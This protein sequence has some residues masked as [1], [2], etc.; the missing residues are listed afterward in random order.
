VRTTLNLNNDLLAEAKAQAAREHLSLTRLIEEGLALR[1][2]QGGKA[3]PSPSSMPLPVYCGQ[4]G[5][6]A[7]VADARSN[8]Q[9]LDAAD[10]LP[11]P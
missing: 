3:A 5:L 8:R 11:Q 6:T 10:G 4:G 1:L 9:M 2:R 7:A